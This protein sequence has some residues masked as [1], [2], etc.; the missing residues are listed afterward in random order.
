M[1]RR[2]V[3]LRDEGGTVKWRGPPG[4]AFRGRLTER[5]IGGVVL[6]WLH[7]FLLMFLNDMRRRLSLR[8]RRRWGSSIDRIGGVVI[9]SRVTSPCL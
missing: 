8:L 1:L 7:N 5:T 2:A 6:L 3:G 4:R 9:L